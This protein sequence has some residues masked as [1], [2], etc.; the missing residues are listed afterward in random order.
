M[1]GLALEGYQPLPPNPPEDNYHREVE[2][3]SDAGSAIA[4]PLDNPEDALDM[5]ENPTTP[6]SVTPLEPLL[7]CLDSLGNVIDEE[8]PRLPKRI[9]TETYIGSM[10]PLFGDEYRTPVHPRTVVATNPTP[11]RSIWRTSMG[12]DLYENFESIRQPFPLHDPPSEIG[13]SGQTMNHPVNR[14]IHSTA[15]PAQ[16]H[17]NVGLI[18]STHPQSTS[19][20]TPISTIFYSTA[21]HVPHDPIGTS[22]HPRK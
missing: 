3:P 1:Q 21:L 11:A 14:V 8:V 17:V 5:V 9:F 4:P 15:T 6:V 22:S 16:V 12:R 7:V 10:E 20:S 18:T 2:N 13:P 19:I